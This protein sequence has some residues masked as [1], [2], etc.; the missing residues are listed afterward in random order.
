MIFFNN[1]EEK[2][3]GNRG[4]AKQDQEFLG[5]M[6]RFVDVDAINNDLK[7]QFI[8]KPFKLDLTP[9][10]K[11]AFAP[12]LEEPKEKFSLLLEFKITIP[13][14]YQHAGHLD[15]FS[16]NNKEKF[17][18]YNDNI[19][20]KKFGKVS[21]QLIPG[22]TYLVKI[23]LINKGM[24]ASSQEILNLLAI[25]NAYLTGA[26][27]AAMLWEQKKDALPKGKWYASFDKKENLP[28]ARGNTIVPIINCVSGGG[29]GFDLGYF[30]YDWND[31]GCVLGFLRL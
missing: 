27:G 17:D 10:L 16:K 8:E 15:T 28:L 13:P 14:D 23:W 25:N 7:Q 6:T 3:M 26:H 4:I 5:H 19:A 1:L 12:K 29:F 30:E 20:D 24:I 11:D 21:H 18:F 22:E 2:A 31:D 9:I